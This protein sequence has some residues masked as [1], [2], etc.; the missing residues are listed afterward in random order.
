MKSESIDMYAQKVSMERQLTRAFSARVC[1]VQ[2]LIVTVRNALSNVTWFHDS[3]IIKVEMYQLVLFCTTQ[4]CGSSYE[5]V[6]MLIFQFIMA[7]E[8]DLSF[9]ILI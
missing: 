1:V 9:I 3:T 6:L 5:N 7:V 8:H 2:Q 4:F